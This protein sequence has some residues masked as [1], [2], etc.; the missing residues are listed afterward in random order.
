[1]GRMRRM[2]G[3]PRRRRRGPGPRLHA[4]GGPSG[5]GPAGR[6]HRLRGGQ[7][8]G[9]GGLSHGG[10]TAGQL[11][12][13]SAARA[14]AHR[15][16]PLHPAPIHDPG[17]R[18]A[19]VR[20]ARG[21]SRGRLDRGN[22][23]S[24]RRSSL[25]RPRGGRR[26]P[27][28][29]S[30]GAHRLRH[31]RRRGTACLVLARRGRNEGIRRHRGNHFVR[32]GVRRPAGGRQRPHGAAC[33]EDRVE[34]R[35]R[36]RRPGP[37]KPRNRDEMGILGNEGRRGAQRGRGLGRRADRPAAHVERRFPRAPFRPFPPH[38]HGAQPRGAGRDPLP[39][40]R[41]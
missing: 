31:G 33:G 28:A 18:R 39:V 21:P 9:N 23:G 34:G 3:A 4:A 6:S 20:V 30:G 36:R 17:G 40:P 13:G 1:M 35:P 8:P 25:G 38:A 11:A 10:G 7:R 16:G 12:A 15:Q 29:S 19:G 2:P 14:R 32:P 26:G 5:D 27:R 37:W 22:A 41:P 24:R